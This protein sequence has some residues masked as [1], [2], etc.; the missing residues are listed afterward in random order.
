MTTDIQQP[1]LLV[2]T[3]VYVPDPAALGQHLHDLA[4]EVAGRGIDV[5]V[6][7]SARGYDNAES[8]YP[9]RETR[10]GVVIRRFGAASFGKRSLL[11]RIIAQFSLLIQAFVYGVFT[12][13]LHGVLISTS[14]PFASAVAMAIALFRRVPILYWVM[15]INP[16]QA[17]SLGLFSERSLPVRLFERLNRRILRKASTV[18]VLDPLMERRLLD[19]L[20]PGERESLKQ[21][22]LVVP[23]WPLDDRLRRIPHSEN[24]FRIRQGWQDKC[25][26]MYS[27]NHAI[28]H[29]IATVLEA[30]ERLA[31]ER[32]DIL[33]AFIGGGK[34]KPEVEAA[35]EKQR[36]Q[37]E[38]VNIV[39]LPYQPLERL[40]ESLSA[41]DVHLV[42]IGNESVG[43]VH[44]C[45]IYGA[46]ALAKPVLL[47]GPRRN[48]FTH[49]LEG[50]SSDNPWDAVGKQV[51]HGDIEGMVAAIRALADL[52]EEERERL[53]ACGQSLIAGLSKD[54][55]CGLLA[56]QVCASIRRDR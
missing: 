20:P 18:V 40:A 26:A 34:R 43:I 28:S 52:T 4:R 39:S 35:I 47:L 1:V 54:R 33:F 56:D 37:G 8:V 22:I 15:D 45:K 24:V 30:A 46:L 36:A 6:L 51:E 9:K 7:A 49:R 11:F 3:Q 55:L 27:G 29:P 41:A 48:H 32:P 42:S 10:D 23:P 16:D 2:I 38:P 14:P 13:K 5:R 12:R 25:V 44:P 50:E 19:K 21:K 31:P 17:V 53:G